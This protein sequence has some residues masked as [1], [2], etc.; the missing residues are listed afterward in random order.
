MGIC[1]SV[2]SEA[3]RR[4]QEI[5]NQLK[6]DMTKANKEV[7]LLLL[8]AGESGKSTVLKQMKLITDKNG[9]S[10]NERRAFK[11]IINS[12]I[13]F[14][15]KT[16]LQAME[17]LKVPLGSRENQR[18]VDLII[19]QPDQIGSET[20]D[21]DVVYA[22]KTLWQDSGVKSCFKRSGNEYHLN[23]SA[24]YYFDSLDRITAPGYLPD[25]QDI[26]RSRVK[27]TGIVETTFPLKNMTFRMFDVGGQRSERKKWIHCFENVNAI[28]FLAA[29]SEYDQKLVE[30]EEVNRMQEAFTL[31]DSICTSRWFSKTSIILFLNKMDIFEEK[32]YDVPIE[33][34]FDDYE[35][36]A[37]LASAKDYFRQRFEEIMPDTL[38]G[39]STKKVY[40]HF[41]CATD[42]K[43]IA[44]VMDAVCN[45]IITK[46]LKD[47]DLI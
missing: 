33:E 39:D 47:A 21:D 19:A 31:F 24:K 22:L 18:H 38:E 28:I 2:D 1:V 7:K 11:S 34:Y 25:D 23:D 16:I 42:T 37:D 26:L 3:V 36:G 15:M 45:I 46:A 13:I 14:S 10:E 41:T 17:N 30:D 32:I 8:G 35:G 43:G 6:I 40:T 4:N 9:Y 5:E 27:T 29:I 20:M 44:F 12:N